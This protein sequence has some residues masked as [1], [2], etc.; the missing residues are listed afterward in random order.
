MREIH[1]HEVNDCNKQIVIT[2]DE[3][4]PANGN[5]SHHYNIL[6]PTFTVM[7]PFQDGPI[8]EV[9]VNGVT[10]EVLLAIIIDRMRGFQSSQYACRENALALTKLEEAAMWLFERTRQRELRGVEGTHK[11]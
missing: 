4:S 8:K 10:H 9:G 6:G 7:L 11:L 5:A 3:Q 1:G 2:A